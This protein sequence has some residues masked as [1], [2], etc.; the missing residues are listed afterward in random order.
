MTAFDCRC[1]PV[2]KA[3]QCSKEIDPVMLQAAQAQAQAQQEAEGR[4]DT[5]A[6]RD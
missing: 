6:G 4:L 1:L 3:N 5:G 2:T